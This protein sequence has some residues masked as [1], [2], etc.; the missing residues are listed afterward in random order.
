M[1][2]KGKDELTE[3]VDEF[4]DVYDRWTSY[5]DRPRIRIK[6]ERMEKGGRKKRE[7]AMVRRVNKARR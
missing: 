6:D 1:T 5:N 4:H 3:L 2:K 7:K